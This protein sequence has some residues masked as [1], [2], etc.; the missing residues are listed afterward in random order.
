MNDDEAE[1]DTGYDP[2]NWQEPIEEDDEDEGIS[3]NR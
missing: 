1:S 2:R 3:W